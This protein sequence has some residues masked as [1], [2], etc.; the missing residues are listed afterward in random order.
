MTTMFFVFDRKLYILMKW[1]KSH[2]VFIM[3]LCSMQKKVDKTFSTLTSMAMYLY[4]CC[5]YGL[6]VHLGI[7]ISIDAPTFVFKITLLIL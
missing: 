4:I 2:D 7:I 6:H 1:K 3:D 5:N